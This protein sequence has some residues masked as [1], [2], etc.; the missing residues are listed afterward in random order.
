MGL[1]GGCAIH[2]SLSHLHQA[3]VIESNGQQELPADDSAPSKG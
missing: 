2:P 3:Q 1:G